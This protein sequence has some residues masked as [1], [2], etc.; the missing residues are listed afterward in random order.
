MC[1]EFP[2]NVTGHRTDDD[3]STVTFEVKAGASA[4]FRNPKD[5]QTRD[6]SSKNAFLRH[7]FPPLNL[8]VLGG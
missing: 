1:N 3:G 2:R 8:I 5:G 6:P 4:E 7:D